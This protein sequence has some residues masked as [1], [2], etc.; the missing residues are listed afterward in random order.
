MKIQATWVIELEGQ[1]CLCRL[2]KNM[3]NL[4]VENYVLLNGLTEDLSPG[5]SLSALRDCSKEVR[6]EPGYIGVLLLIKEKPDIS[7]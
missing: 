6:E 1:S 3:H 7:S 4:Q 2:K 5:Y